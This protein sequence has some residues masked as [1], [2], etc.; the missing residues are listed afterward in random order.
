MELPHLTEEYVADRLARSRFRPKTAQT[1]TY[2]LRGLCRFVPDGETL[3]AAHLEAWLTGTKMAPATARTRLSQV[4]AF[5]Q[6]LIRHGHLTTDPSSLV[7]GPRPPR[8]VPRGLKA[9][10][11]GGTLDVA[12]DARARV[13]LLLMCQEGL[14]CGE[15]AG[16]ELGDVDFED[17]LMLVRGKGGHQRVLPLTDE[18]W[19]AIAEYLTEHPAYAGPLIRSYNDPY[20]GIDAS[21]VST[22]VARWIRSA[23]VEATAHA[24]RHTAATDMLRSG[25]HLRDVQAALGH[26][27]L[28]TTQRYLPW[29][30]GSLK[31]AMGGRKYGRAARPVEEA[32]RLVD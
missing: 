31:E 12:P 23:G 8:Y 15:V 22:L 9:A 11:V 6:W 27:S 32:A 25:A 16:L 7:D 26:V 1:V 21:Y 2:T 13:I 17:Q 28:S 14:R 24:L 5:C 30:V 19:G 29:T 3:S 18:T 20:R 10:A 4:R